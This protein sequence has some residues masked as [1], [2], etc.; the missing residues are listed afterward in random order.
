MKLPSVEYLYNNAKNSFV[1]FPLTVIM[2]SIAVMF[3]IYLIEFFKDTL[4]VF[5]YIN[6]ML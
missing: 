4:N 6:I 2:S 5:P 1:R 3:G